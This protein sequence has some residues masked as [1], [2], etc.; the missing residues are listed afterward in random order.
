[1]E[2]FEQLLTCA[3]CLDRYRNPKLLPCQH[4]FCME[5]CM[6]GLVDYVRRQV[7]CPEC[8][9][10]HRIPYQ[11]VQGFPTNVTLQR[12]LELHIEITGELPDPTSGQVMK[13]CGVCS[14]KAYC[15][16]C[17]HCEKDICPD[18]KGAHM[19]ILRREIS[20]INNQV[21]R[22]LHRLQ[23]LLAV[24]EKNMLALQTNCT[25]VSDEVDEIYRRLNKALKDR[26]EF[27]RGEIDRYLSTELKNLNTLK[28]NLETE[29]SNIQANCD[30]ADKHMQSEEI[31]WDDCELMDAKEIFLKTVEFVRNFEAETG[32][33]TR[34][35]RFIMAHDPN[36]LV[37]HVAGYGDLS[38][39]M[40]HQFTGNQSSNQ[41]GGGMLQPPGPGLMRSKSDH[42]LAS[43]YRQQEQYDRGYEGSESGRVSPLGGRK[44]GERPAARNT[45][46][47]YEGGRYGRNRDRG[48]YGG[49][50]DSPYDEGNRST[51]RSRIRARMN[52][53]A[54]GDSD[55]D[56][57][58]GRSVRFT[59]GSHTQQKERERVLDTEDVAKGPLSG[60]TRLYDSPRVMKRLQDSETKKDKPPPP[61]APPVQKF[62]PPKRPVAAAQRQISEEDEVTK[63]KRLMKNAPG[64]PASSAPEPVRPAADRVSALKGRSEEEREDRQQASSPTS[65]SSRSTPSSEPTTRKPSQEV[66]SSEADSDDGS[67]VSS[68]QQTQRK[69][70]VAAK[71]TPTSGSRRSSTSSEVTTTGPQP[72]LILVTC[73]LAASRAAP[74][75]PT[76]A[77]APASPRLQHTG[78][79][80]STE[81][82]KRRFLLHSDPKEPE[83][84]KP[85]VSR[86]LKRANRASVGTSSTPSTPTTPTAPTPAAKVEEDEEEESS[87]ESS[88][89]EESESEEESDDKTKTVTKPMEKTDI[90]P[91]LAR[92][93]QA[94]DSGSGTSTRRSSKDEGYT[95]RWGDQSYLTRESSQAPA[96]IL[97][98]RESQEQEV[99]GNRYGDSSY[100]SRYG[101]KD[102]SSSTTP[103]WRSRTST[104]TAEE[105]P[106]SSRYGPGGFQSRF[107]NKSKSTAA[108]S[109]EEEAPER[110]FSSAGTDDSRYPSTARSRYSALK[111]RKTRL[112][113]SKSSHNFGADEDEDPD[114]TT[115]PAAYMAAKG[116]GQSGSDLARSRSTHTLKSRE[117]SPERPSSTAGAS[118]GE[119]D[120]AALSSWARY[121][122]NKYGN[123]GK[124]GK[125][126][127]SGTASRRLSLGLP[128]RTNSEDSSADDQKNLPG[129][130]T[131]PTQV[132][133]PAGFAAVGTK[134]QYLQKRRMLFKVGSRGSEPGCFTWPRGIAVAPDNS[135]VV[136]D[137]S[138]H[139]VQVF[140]SNGIFSKEFGSYG[141][142][143]GEF[144]CL[145][146]VAVNRIGQ[147]IIA[148]RYNHRIQVMDPS[149]RFLRSFGSQGTA[150]GRF[151]YPWGITTDALGFIYVC[152]KENHR[153]QVFQSDGTFVGKFG[154]HG[155]KQGQLEHPHYIAV[156]N[157]N[158]VI[159]SD[160]NN[161]RIQVFDV[162]GRVLNSFGTEGSE[163]GQFKFPRN[164][165]PPSKDPTPAKP[166]RRGGR[167]PRVHNRRGLRQQPH[168]DLQP[169]RQLPEGVRVLGLGRRGVQGTGGSRSDV[170]WEHSGV[171]PRESP[172]SGL[173]RRQISTPNQSSP[174]YEVD[175]E[176]PTSNVHSPK[177]FTRSISFEEN[178]VSTELSREQSPRYSSIDPN[179]SPSLLTNYFRSSSLE[180]PISN[181]NEHEISFR[182]PLHR[183]TPSSTSLDRSA[184]FSR[185]SSFEEYSRN[186][187]EYGSHKLDFPAA[188]DRKLITPSQS[189]F[190]SSALGSIVPCSSRDHSFSSRPPY[191]GRS[192]SYE[193]RVPCDIEYQNPS[194]KRSSSPSTSFLQRSAGNT[195]K[196]DALR[197]TISYEQSSITSVPAPVFGRR[198]GSSGQNPR[199]PLLSRRLSII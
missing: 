138:N 173:L 45:G 82:V 176:R 31:E 12:F 37:L 149:G 142:A 70:S 62:Q 24:V 158:K 83:P 168:P 140:D 160:S 52:R 184:Y 9:A 107:L 25:S 96:S 5:P 164:A 66:M 126:T 15:S 59:E 110:K 106:T 132:M 179:S 47:Q 50:Y 195:G 174:K 119:K 30:L 113:R 169:G 105:E 100:Q 183:E 129:S 92:S 128:L 99:T 156:S 67:S 102:D 167:R 98:R 76:P 51:A 112:A 123:R 88:E 77:P 16:M 2:Q 191:F 197:R 69:T 38:I 137:S 68:L 63:I 121:L 165:L 94:R 103:S 14:E 193:G 33:Y 141:N 17:V 29:I 40:P 53:H 188:S 79:V 182:R 101:N 35:A 163:N 81:E 74:A 170:Q 134:N 89:S 75:A 48:D 151:N 60:I 91:L 199:R 22:G 42:R 130:P 111:D 87:E 27:L 19:D 56:T 36:Q 109:P 26:T 43:Q 117:N 187:V 28:D 127:S 198:P 65:G 172:P 64:E 55:D 80:F 189:T 177:R 39:N 178:L 13:R 145:A 115:S 124:D 97:K 58:G 7:K 104:T 171:R 185:A 122:K 8:R 196:P 72:P 85:F 23:D 146:G 135:I 159:V 57:S 175:L 44:F 95:S 3:I 1:M 6:D 194:F 34:K 21:R 18:C 166:T 54:A 125:D 147:F 157:T 90:G 139:R 10:E 150:D 73:P 143:E 161:H 108:V 148:D 180:E 41:S 154:S 120:G 71:T 20:R 4:S 86:F 186:N 153:V 114:E 181:S 144:D 131:S 11:G 118:S 93:Q 162:N 116:Y 133:A 155:S 78:A 84:K 32:D 152:D 61:A 190:T 136:A 46:D 49:D 192:I